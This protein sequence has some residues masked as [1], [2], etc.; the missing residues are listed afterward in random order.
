[1]LYVYAT[2][3]VLAN[4]VWLFL[5]VLGLPGNWL[6][7]LTAAVMT[8]WTWGEDPMFSITVLIAA[9]VI[10]L[11]GELLEFLL[12]AVGARKAGGSRRAA[13]M[14][15][16]GAVAGGIVATFLIPIPI[17]GTLIGVCAGAFIG[18]TTTEIVIG[19]E[20]GASLQSGRGAA[21]G[22][23]YGTVAKVIVGGLMFALLAVAAFV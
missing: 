21:V 4:V 14:S 5:T 19:K 3:L 7:V 13:A 6:M 11:V 1:M 12:G 17:L 10:G 18:A 16:V 23:L 8:W 15:I 9:T 20:I 2:G 22:R